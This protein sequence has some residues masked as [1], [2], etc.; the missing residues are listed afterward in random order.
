MEKSNNSEKLII[1]I[2]IGSTLTKATS[3]TISD[4]K[5]QA[6][7]GKGYALTTV[8][9]GDVAEGL[10]NALEDLVYKAKILSLDKAVLLGNSSAAGGL[11]MTVH[12]LVPEMTAKAAKEAALGAG[13]VVKMVTSGMLREEDLKK[14]EEVSPKLMLLAG[15]VDY[16]ESEV[17]VKNAHLISRLKI[18]VPII[19][20]G[21]S[22]VK[23][24]VSQILEARGFK[25]YPTENV[26]PRLDELNIEPVK[27]IIQKAFEEHIT[28]GP[29]MYSI[30]DWISGVL[31]PTPGAVMNAFQLLSNVLGDVIGFDVG[32]ATTDVHSV[33]DGDEEL[34]KI[35]P[36]HE[37][38]SKRTVEGDLGVYL[39]ANQVIDLFEG[40]EKEDLLARTSYITPL[41]HEQEEIAITSKITQKAVETA[42]L[43]HVGEIRYV[44]SPT[45]R[46]TYVWGK[47]LTRVK[48]VIGTGGALVFLPGMRQFLQSLFNRPS[49]RLLLPNNPEVLIDNNYLL[50]SI[51]TLARYQLI[52]RESLANF[53]LSNLN[54]QEI[55]FI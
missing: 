51:G 36:Y 20:A 15:G 38:K 12:G 26:Y 37:P 17:I 9:I 7:L 28:E 16:G 32:G 33:T 54:N 49:S 11:R 3:F 14:I 35:T 30:K 45:G 18:K 31:L 24:E 29:G 27:K 39:S 47:D 10:K 23:S 50:S 41:S 43:R 21:N 19:Y 52:D 6:F 5:I 34:K 46:G 2:E 4:G 22:A 48:W 13:A 44:M 42:L 53:A 40:A 55:K 1:V 25:V 8:K